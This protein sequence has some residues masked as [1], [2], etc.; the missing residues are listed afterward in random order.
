MEA[1]KELVMLEQLKFSRR[2]VKDLLLSS[3]VIGFILH[4]YL[5]LKTGN[6]VLNILISTVVA[7]PAFVFHEIAHKLVAQRYDCKAEYYFL[8]QWAVTSVFLSLFGWA[9]GVDLIFATVGAVMISTAYETRIGFRFVSLTM[10]ERGKIALA[11]PATNLLLLVLFKSLEPFNSIFGV[12]AYLNLAIAFFN[13][14]PIPP[15]DGSK[16][17]SWSIIPWSA[18]FST[19]LLFLLFM[20]LIPLEGLVALSL[21]IW[22]IL[23]LWLQKYTKVKL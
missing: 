6:W 5:N 20:D 17:F 1:F 7:A 12:A 3:L 11:G 15:L 19:E 22:I 16:V 4:L 2:E 18:L 9:M 10:E 13:T 21:I 23:F 8:P 14:L